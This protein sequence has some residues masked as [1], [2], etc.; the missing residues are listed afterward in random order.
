[1]QETWI[2]SAKSTGPWMW[3]CGLKANCVQGNPEGYMVSS[4]RS[5]PAGIAW[6]PSSIPSPTS[7]FIVLPGS[8]AI[9][10]TRER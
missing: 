3:Q 4:G 7:T 6:S 8:T 9:W 10:E 1:M 5:V 2:A